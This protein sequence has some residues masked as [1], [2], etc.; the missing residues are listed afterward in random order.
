MLDDDAGRIG[1]AK[2]GDEFERGV[3][4]VDIIV[5]KLLALHLFSLRDPARGGAGGQVERRLLVR[6]LAIAQL[7]GELGGQRQRD[8]KSKRLNSSHSCASRMPSSA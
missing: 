8:R 3:G 7:V 5:G 6:I 2:F 4:V 1:L